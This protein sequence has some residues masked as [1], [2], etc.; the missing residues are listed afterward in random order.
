MHELG[1]EALLQRY[2]EPQTP[3]EMSDAD[4][5]LDVT[6]RKTF[7]A[8][9]FSEPAMCVGGVALMQGED[10]V[11]SAIALGV[12]SPDFELITD[13]QSGSF[14]DARDPDLGLDPEY[15]RQWT[16][17][18]GMATLKSWAII[19]ADNLSVMEVF[20]RFDNDRNVHLTPTGVTQISS[21]NVGLI[22]DPNLVYGRID[23]IPYW[24]DERKYREGVTIEM[25]T[26]ELRQETKRKQTKM[27]IGY[28]RRDR[29]YHVAHYLYAYGDM[30]DYDPDRIGDQ[31]EELL[32]ILKLP[33]VDTALEVCN[34]ISAIKDS[35][36]IEALLDAAVDYLA[37]QYEE[38]AAASGNPLRL[39]DNDRQ[40]LRSSRENIVKG[41]V[42]T[43]ILLDYSYPGADIVR[44]VSPD[45]IQDIDRDAMSAS[46]ALAVSFMNAT[47]G[48]I[49]R[50]M[51]NF[52]EIYPEES[53][54][55]DFEI[56]QRLTSVDIAREILRRK[57][58]YTR[59]ML[60]DD[61]HWLPTFEPE[62]IRAIIGQEVT[63][64]RL[65]YFEPNT[66]PENARDYIF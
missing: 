37:S 12:I 26:S 24:I 19:G 63:E 44:M 6:E 53:V 2:N 65:A 32:P 27:L 60:P 11:R 21:S 38:M 42:I 47:N 14:I 1:P 58:V 17:V 4:Y 46:R 43:R 59:L 31:I 41:A 55:E 8:S 36:E 20:E 18:F 15:V 9:R 49:E 33:D 22:M 3:L 45:V 23:D 50:A 64:G 30:Y 62:A 29:M 61:W 40:R 10:A 35:A 39:N 52:D 56:N 34:V 16:I 54:R 5:L 25:T 66:P 57:L 48:D 51:E 13:L 7:R 28:E